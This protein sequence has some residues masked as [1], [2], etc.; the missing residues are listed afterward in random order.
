MTLTKTSLV[1]FGGYKRTYSLFLK[2]IGK[3]KRTDICPAFHRQTVPQGNQIVD[4]GKLPFME[5]FQPINGGGIIE[6]EYQHFAAPNGIMDLGNDQHLLR[7][8]ARHCIS[9]W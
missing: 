4:E 6:L 1:I 8:T 5:V 2:Y 3:G 9:P 7:K